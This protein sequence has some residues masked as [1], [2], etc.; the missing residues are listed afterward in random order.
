MC[1]ANLK[2]EILKNQRQMKFLGVNTTPDT[3]LRTVCLIPGPSYRARSTTLAIT[4]FLLSVTGGKQYFKQEVEL[5]WLRGH[6][7]HDNLSCSEVRIEIS[8]FSGVKSC[9]N[10]RQLITH[11]VQAAAEPRL[12]AE[13]HA[14]SPPGVL[15]D[16]AVGGRGGAARQD[17]V[18]HAGP[19]LLHPTHGVGRHARHRPEVSLAL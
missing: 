2:G 11:L 14:G 8:S 6:F 7:H 18:E 1:V 4:L 3:R 17:H 5:L 9:L 16:G 19:L 12:T 15:D 13:P 10:K